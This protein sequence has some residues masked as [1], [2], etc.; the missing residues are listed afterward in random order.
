MLQSGE[1]YSGCRDRGR[2]SFGCK[3]ENKM[4]KDELLNLALQEL[5]D[6]WSFYGMNLEVANWHM[7]GD[8]EPLDA[9]LRV[10]TMGLWML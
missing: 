8:L 9:F 3:E 2:V 7:N 6:L 10:V 1:R 4:T 5:E